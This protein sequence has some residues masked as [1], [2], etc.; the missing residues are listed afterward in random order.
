[1]GVFKFACLFLEM[2]PLVQGSSR[3]RVNRRQKLPREK[4]SKDNVNAYSSYQKTNARHFTRIRTTNLSRHQKVQFS[5]D[6]NEGRQGR[7]DRCFCPEGRLPRIRF[8]N[9]SYP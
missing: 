7:R 6:F 9:E 3:P 1:M 5:R 2:E 4:M 8:V